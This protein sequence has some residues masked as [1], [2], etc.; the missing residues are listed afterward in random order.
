MVSASEFNRRMREAQRKAQR[1]VERQVDQINRANKKAVDDYN[2]RVLA[3]ARRVDQNNKRVINEHNRQIDTVNKHN[4]QAF[5]SLAAAASHPRPVTYTV[6]ERRLVERVQ[7]A[8]LHRDDREYDVFLSYARLDGAEVAQSLRDALSKLGIQV[9]HDE[10]AIVPGKSMALQ[11]DRGLQRARA[12][13]ALLTAS[14]LT[15]RFWTERELG[16]LLHKETLIPV[17]HRVTFADVK[18]YSGIL[19]D[20]AGF[21]TEHDTIE[22]IAEKIAVA[23]LP[24]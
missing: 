12:G 3:E 23:V 10:L 17:L 14:Y 16:A 21:T 19:P 6:Q 7:E 2:R 8:A 20:L 1:A 18:E 22:T 24:R 11:M 15:G 4:E 9:W 13:V 5:R